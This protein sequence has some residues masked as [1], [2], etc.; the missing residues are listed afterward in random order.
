MCFTL[1]VG[2]MGWTMERN[3]AELDR[4]YRT[5]Q[6]KA[7]II[8]ANASLYVPAGFI[9]HRTVDTIAASEFVQSAYLEASTMSPLV[10]ALSGGGAPDYSRVDKNVTLRAFDR[11]EQFFTTRG[12]DVTVE[13]ASG[14]DESLFTES[15]TEDHASPV[16]LS[17]SMMEQLRLQSG[18]IIMID[19]STTGANGGF[20]IAGQY[21][22]MISEGDAKTILLPASALKLLERNE[23]LY[24]VAEFVL[25]PARNREL[26]EFRD[27]LNAFSK[28]DSG[29]VNLTFRILDEELKEVVEPMEKNLLLMS[30]LYPVTV[31]VS[32]IIAAGLVALLIFQAAK[33][34]ALM[35]V[36]GTTKTRTRAILCG[37]QLSLS[38]VGLLLGL[39]LLVMLRQ[40]VSTVLAGPALVCAGLY[41]AGAFSGAMFSAISVTNRMPL[42]LL[43]VKE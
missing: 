18:D 36:L 32:T 17:A 25:D 15:W 35:R 9:R 24:D 8:K 27:Q 33:E 28:M 13:Y 30:I 21:T 38:L 7:D 4:L 41:L 39:A 37:E 16:L 34:A 1:A 40:D 3:E 14:W 20:V 12:S 26:P 31:S 23:P 10:T 6:V 43:Q 29:I 5:T 2:W 42:D 22:G 19:G 11:P